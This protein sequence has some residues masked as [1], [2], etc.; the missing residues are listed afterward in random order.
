MLFRSLGQSMAV[1]F[2]AS[3]MATI[4][5]ELGAVQQAAEVREAA[6]ITTAH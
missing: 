3:E 1:Q 6:V 5:I 4:E 2:A